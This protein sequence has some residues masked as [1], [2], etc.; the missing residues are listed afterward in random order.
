LFGSLYFSEGL[1]QLLLVVVVP[2]Y[3][4]E[5]NI[6]IPIITLVFAIGQIPWALKFIWGSIADRYQKYGRRKFTIIGTIIG[7]ISFLILA[8]IDQ[9]FSIVFFTIFLFIGRVGISFLDVSADAWVIDITKKEERGKLNASMNTG[10]EISNALFSPIIIIT[11]LTFGFHISF[12]LM[13]LIILLVA[14][15]PI[16]VK[17]KIIKIKYE[18]IWYLMKNEFKLKSTRLSTLYIFSATLNPGII[19]PLIV[20]YAKTVLNLDDFTIGLIGAI[21]LISII[22]GSYVGGFLADKY[23]RKKTSML[24]LVLIMITPLIFILTTDLLPTIILLGILDFVWN[25]MFP[26]NVSLIM[27]IINPKIAASE[28]SLIGSCANIGGL[29]SSS[30]AGT[31]VILI[32]FQNIFILSSLLVIPPIIILYN[33]NIQK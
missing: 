14:I 5:K 8:L 16:I 9:Y 22:P 15:L 7:S 32:G 4:I 6:P 27:D 3:L 29:I 33:L 13:G 10:K 18:K 12:I 19:V 17:E 1:Y 28:F 21:L 2:L 20:I 31:L 30:I 11:A 26:S 24:F 25:G 23:G